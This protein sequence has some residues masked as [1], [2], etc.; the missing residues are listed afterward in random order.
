MKTQFDT[1]KEAQ[2]TLR[3]ARLESLGWCPVIKEGCKGYLT[4]PKPCICY[5]EGRISEPDE[6]STRWRVHYPYCD[7]VLIS[8]VIDCNCD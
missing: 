7:H 5:C 2:E 6:D 3:K 8:G 4:K 1:E